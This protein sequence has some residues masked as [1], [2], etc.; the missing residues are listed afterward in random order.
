M[1]SRKRGATLFL[2]VV[3]VSLCLPLTLFRINDDPIYLTL[4]LIPLALLAWAGSRSRVSFWMLIALVGGVV[5]VLAAALIDPEDFTV[6]SFLSLGLIIGTASFLFLGKYLVERFGLR[7]VVLWL[8]L[9]SSVSIFAI[10]GRILLFAET[11][12]IYTLA[13]ESVV[14]A[15]FFGLEIFGSFGILSLTYLF[16][17]QLIVVC[18]GTFLT[19]L[20]LPVRIFFLLNVFLGSYLVWGSESR[21][22]QILMLVLVVSFIVYAARNRRRLLGSVLLAVLAVGGVALAMQSAHSF[23]RISLTFEQLVAGTEESVDPT[24]STDETDSDADDNP[25]ADEPSPGQSESP[26][27]EPTPP[28]TDVVDTVSTGRLTL[29]KQAVDEILASPVTGNGFGQ[30]GRFADSDEPPAVGG[31]TSTHIYYLT[32]LWKG[33]LIFMLPFSVML[34][35]SIRVAFRR[36][37]PKQRIDAETFFLRAGIVSSFIIMPAFWDILLVPSAGAFAFLLLGMLMGNPKIAELTSPTG[38]LVDS[39]HGSDESSDDRAQVV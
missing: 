31:S 23:D 20:A 21:S 1:T 34:V 4:V 22:A 8:S 14:N 19:K 33:G 25:V 24:S 32:L 27:G 6:R 30:Y 26:S 2:L 28:I 3:V 7:K 12:R 39:S 36:G 29:V 11:V 15:K 37:P 9:A 13:G 38:S 16:F 10:A 18:A 35:M 17:L 5:S